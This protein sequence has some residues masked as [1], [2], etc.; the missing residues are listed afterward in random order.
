MRCKDYLTCN[1]RR[2]TL[3]VTRLLDASQEGQVTGM[4]LTAQHKSN[5]QPNTP[6]TKQAARITPAVIAQFVKLHE[7]VRTLLKNGYINK[8][9]LEQVRK[10]D[11]ILATHRGLGTTMTQLRYLKCRCMWPNF[12]Q[13]GLL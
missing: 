2:V 3:W 11:N 7:E 12:D 8:T 6:I 10:L 13:F 4:K 9:T 5:N 1:V